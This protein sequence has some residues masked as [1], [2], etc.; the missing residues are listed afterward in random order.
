MSAGRGALDRSMRSVVVAVVMVATGAGA[1]GAAPWTVAAKGGVVI[2]W[3]AGALRASGVGPADRHA[4]SPAVA[5]VA[6][7]RAAVAQ[8]RARLAAAARALPVAAGG[9]VGDGVDAAPAAAAR[10]A[11]ELER[12]P[13]V[14]FDLHTDGSARVTVALGIEAVRQAMTGPRPAAIDD[15]PLVIWIVAAA[16][17]SP[18]VDPTIAVGGARWHGPVLWVRDRADA[19]VAPGAIEARAVAATA[20]VLTVSG[21]AAPPP[22]GALV[23]VVVP[24]K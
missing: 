3:S 13:V 11:A 21:P 22:A 23:V 16:A 18:A 9:T 6:A 5:R 14:G 8:A 1:A 2:D 10:F 12:A 20:G 4:P 24:E 17:T 15:G 7:R 19:P